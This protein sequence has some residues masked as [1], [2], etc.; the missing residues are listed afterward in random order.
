MRRVSWEGVAGRRTGCWFSVPRP[1]RPSCEVLM[2]GLLPDSQGFPNTLRPDSFH[3]APGSGC[4]SANLKNDGVWALGAS[5]SW[6]PTT[7]HGAVRWT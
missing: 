6:P 5:E 7:G 2:T 3:T 1:T 4:E